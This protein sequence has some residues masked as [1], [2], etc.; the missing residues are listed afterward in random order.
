M[1]WEAIGA[2]GEIV[3]ALVVFGTL[4]Y[5]ALQMKQVRAEVHLASFRDTNRQFGNV[6]TSASASPDLAKALAKADEDVSS[7]TQWELKLL[8]NHLNALMA[9]WETVVEQI[10]T[11]ALK[12]PREEVISLIGPYLDESWA[13]GAWER[14]KKY[15]LG[16]FRAVVES[17]L[18]GNI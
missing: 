16:D 18:P 3:G 4:L 9:A 10:D 15:H 8:D 6:F 17:Q 12:V 11:G 2:I 13:P 5:L 1:N 14:I 7:L